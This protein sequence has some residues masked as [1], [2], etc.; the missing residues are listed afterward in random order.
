M[1]V[2]KQIIISRV[3]ELKI[4]QNVRVLYNHDLN[5]INSSKNIRVQF[6]INGDIIGAITCHLCL[7]N[8]DLTLEEKNF[9]FPLFVEAMNILIGKQISHDV[10]ISH[11]K[12]VLNPPKLNL[13]S[14]EINSKLKNTIHKYELELDDKSFIVLTEYNLTY[15]N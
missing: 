7:D 4:L 15:F 14:L 6:D 13:N 11:L 3:Q 10:E 2:S 5:P 8:I 1:D 9:I 12:V